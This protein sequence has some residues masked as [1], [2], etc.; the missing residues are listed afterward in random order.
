MGDWP[1]ISSCLTIK[2]HFWILY[3]HTHNRREA[4][5]IISVTRT[6]NYQNVDYTRLTEIVLLL[7]LKQWW[8]LP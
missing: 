6:F 7:S 5:E 1:H 3:M 2:M 4:M 8:H